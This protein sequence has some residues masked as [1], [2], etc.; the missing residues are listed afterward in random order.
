MWSLLGLVL[1]CATLVAS[2]AAPTSTSSYLSNADKA[3][4][5]KV[6]EPGFQLTDLASLHYAVVGYK[7]IGEAVPKSAVSFCQINFERR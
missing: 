5:K 2:L 4:L 7:L 6:I 1:A 3:R